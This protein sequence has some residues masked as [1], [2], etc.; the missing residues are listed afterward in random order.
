MAELERMKLLENTLIVFMGD[1]GTAA[2]AAP[3]DIIGGKKVVGQKGFMTEGGSLV[4]FIANWKG[5]IAPGKNTDQLIDA[6]DLMPTFAELTGAKLPEKN[7]LDGKSFAPLLLGK[8]GTP[9]DWIFMELG[10]KWYVREAKYKLNREGELFDMSNSPFAE[11]L[12]PAD[13][14]NPEAI[15]ARERLQK[16]LAHLNPEGGI[17][18]D[19]DGSGRAKNKAKKPNDEDG[20]DKKKDKKKDPRKVAGLA[21]PGS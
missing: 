17:L 1:N 6:T 7:I 14:K 3:F 13:T 18:D 11:P 8:K 12:I 20:K 5:K 19:G 9:R 2:K 21:K 4:P 15:A 10:N 16:V